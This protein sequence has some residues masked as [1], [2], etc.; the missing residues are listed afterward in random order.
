MTSSQSMT[1]Y[2]NPATSVITLQCPPLPEMSQAVFFN[3][4][5]VEV[6]RVGLHKGQTTVSVDLSGLQPGLYFVRINGKVA[7]VIKQ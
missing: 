6:R 4:L 7:R 3:S 5:G 1:I 2:P